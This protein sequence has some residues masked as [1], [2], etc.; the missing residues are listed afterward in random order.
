MA[1]K[2]Q[3]KIPQD[4]ISMAQL[5]G[6]LLKTKHSP[7]EAVETVTELLKAKQP[8]KEMRMSTWNHLRRVGLENYAGFFE[9]YGFYWQ[10]ELQHAKLSEMKE[11]VVELKYEDRDM[12][13]LE[14]L[15]KGEES[16]I[17]D[18]Q[19]ADIPTMKEIIIK[20]YAQPE[21]MDQMLSSPIRTRT[22]VTT[23]SEED[24]S[25]GLI[26]VNSN[27]YETKEE[28]IAKKM[29]ESLTEDGKGLVSI[30]QLRWHCEV[31]AKE[32]EEA[33]RM[34][35]ILTDSRSKCKM[36]PQWLDTWSWL[37]RAGLATHEKQ[38][39][40]FK[41]EEEGLKYAK[42]FQHLDK[43]VLKDDF[44]MSKEDVAIAHAIMTK[45]AK[46]ADILQG[47]CCPDRPRIEREFHLAYPEAMNSETISSLA[48]SFSKACSDIHGRGLVSLTMLYEHFKRHADSPE[49]AF[50]AR[51]AELTHVVRVEPE[52]PAPPPEPKDFVAEW[53]KKN[54]LGQYVRNF[55][56]QGFSTEHDLYVYPITDE[57]LEK[58]LGINQ[59]S[60]RRKI[61]EIL[62]KKL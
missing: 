15:L 32:P 49:G 28:A 17:K 21:N 53:L 26:R 43:D 59:L 22:N 4:E 60:H 25:S 37:Q 55:L 33:I 51:E 62:Q 7:S 56:G 48:V 18:Y 6:H 3:K 16:I 1:E 24:D 61:I 13:R 10:D 42:D 19:I 47:F 20:A 14:A 45:D 41:L 2:F 54:D 40:A 34:A 38:K 39:Y 29:V 9:Y 8:Q 36:G 44:D 57:Q 50:S 52:K 58:T 27:H 35:H 31:H 46:R 30:W 11:K 5:Q 23:A 12:A